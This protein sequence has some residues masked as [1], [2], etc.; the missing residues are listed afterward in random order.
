MFAFQMNMKKKLTKSKM[1]KLGLRWFN[2][3]REKKNNKKNAFLNLIY[4]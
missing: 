4:K 1:V 2:D 3:E